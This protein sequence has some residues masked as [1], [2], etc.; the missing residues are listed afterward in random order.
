MLPYSILQSLHMDVDQVRYNSFV[1]SLQADAARSLPSDTIPAP[2]EDEEEWAPAPA[3]NEEFDLDGFAVPHDEIE[4]LL[5]ENADLLAGLESD[6]GASEAEPIPAPE[7]WAG[8][9]GQR[10]FTEGQVAR[11]KQQMQQNFQVVTQ[12][13][14]LQAALHGTQSK[15]AG[16]WRVQ[17]VGFRSGMSRAWRLVLM[18]PSKPTAIDEK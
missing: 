6:L 9:N 3:E 12:A 5:R 17:L 18:F 8:N 14:A 7:N 2:D 15:E 1:K 4:M 11:L 13:Y 10:V 16:I